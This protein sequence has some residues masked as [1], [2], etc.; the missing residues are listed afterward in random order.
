MIDQ[1][2][3]DP[4]HVCIVGMSYGGFAALAGAAFT[5]RL[6]ACANLITRSPINAVASIVSPILIIYATGDG[7]VPNQPGRTPGCRC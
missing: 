7:V 5:P 3:A 2:I 1:G 4:Q 6:Y